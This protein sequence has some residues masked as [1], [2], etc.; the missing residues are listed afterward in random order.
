MKKFLEDLKN[1]FFSMQANEIIDGNL[2]LKSYD[3]KLL[4]IYSKLVSIINRIIKADGVCFIYTDFVN[5]SGSILIGAL[6]ELF[7]FKLYEPS[8]QDFITTAGTEVK[9]ICPDESAQKLNINKQLRYGVLYGDRAKNRQII[10]MANTSENWRG[11][12][13][14]VLIATPKSREGINLLHVTTTDIV[15]PGWNEANNYQAVRRTIRASSGLVRLAMLQAQAIKENRNPDDVRIEISIALHA[16]VGPQ[17]QPTSDTEIYR[18]S[19]SKNILSAK[20][21]RKIKQCRS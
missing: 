10:N 20:L 5:G 1:D 18:I 16:A 3:K 19:E 8:K 15:G 7:G 14:K 2:V 21:N 9:V 4:K 13:V 6:L 11:E 17:G 12:Y